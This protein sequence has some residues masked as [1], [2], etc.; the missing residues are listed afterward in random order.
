MIVSHSLVEFCIIYHICKG[1]WHL[2]SLTISIDLNNMQ[3]ELD[4]LLHIA[5][6]LNLF[7][8]ENHDFVLAM[9]NY[10]IQPS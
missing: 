3:S 10:K 2:R 1:I 9:A 5:I 7:G 8:F 4:D 6:V